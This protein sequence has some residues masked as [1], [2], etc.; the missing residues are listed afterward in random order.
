MSESGAGP[1]P[2]RGVLGTHSQATQHVPL[3]ADGPEGDLLH[4][5]LGQARH[6]GDVA[7]VEGRHL[8][9]RAPQC[10]PTLPVRTNMIS[11]YRP[12]GRD[13]SGRRVSRYLVHLLRLTKSF[14]V[15]CPWK[16]LLEET[17]TDVTPASVTP[18]LILS[19]DGGVRG[20][21]CSVLPALFVRPSGDADVHGPL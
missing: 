20:E 16:D 1:R 19:G 14:K 12:H 2:H 17:R 18:V 13:A 5:A 11:C 21:V 9:P 15:L 7:Q 10:D 6:Q 4:L 3:F 8:L